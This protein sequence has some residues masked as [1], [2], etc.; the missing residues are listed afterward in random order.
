LEYSKIE[1]REKAMKEK[2]GMLQ[3]E[4]RNTILKGR[5]GKIKAKSLV[6]IDENDEKCTCTL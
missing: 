6:K 4:A 1:E 2:S 5:E 3:N